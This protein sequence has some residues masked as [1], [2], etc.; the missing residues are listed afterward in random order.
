MASSK[1]TSKGRQEML[2]RR[3]LGW[4]ETATLVRSCL[5][6]GT[7]YES[8]KQQSFSEVSNIKS[9][10]VNAVVRLCYRSGS[11]V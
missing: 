6:Y 11:I 3:H 10:E 5:P 2:Q 8:K 4:T 7:F 9:R 1:A